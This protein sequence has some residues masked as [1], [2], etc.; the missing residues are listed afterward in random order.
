MKRILLL[1]VALLAGFFAAAENYLPETSVAGL[2]PL[3][4]SGRTVYNFNVGWRFHRGDTP[5]A[6]KADYNDSAWELVST[7][8][9]VML[10]P[11]EGSGS[12]NYQGIAWYRKH[13]TVP[14]D[15]A[16]KEIVLHFEA[17]MGKQVIY[18]NGNKVKEHFGG[19][20][21]ITVNLT[22]AGVAAG[23][24]CVVAL[25]A[26]NSDDGSYLPGKP[27]YVLD[28]AYHGGIYRDVWLIGKGKV[29]ITDPIE[30][31]KVAGGG[32][33]VHYDNIS[34]QSADIFVDT[35]LRN[36][37]TRKHTVTL[38]T[39]LIDKEGKVLLTN[40]SRLTLKAGESRTAQQQ[41]KLKT[42]NLWAPDTPYLYRMETRIA[43][44]GEP[45]DGGVLRIGIRKVE[46]KG[47]EGLW[48]NGKPYP[49]KLMGANRHQD[50]AYVGNAVPNSQQWNDAVRLRE[51]G[52]R[53]IRCAHYPQDPAFMDACDE[54][55][56]FVIVATPGWQFWNNDPS[57]A[58]RS[59]QNTRDMIRVERNHPCVIMWE[60]ILNETG[61]PLEFST[62]A[63]RVTQ[64]EFPYPGA[65]VAAADYNSKGVMENY[66]VIY[67]NSRVAQTTD[68]TVFT[69]EWGDMVDDWYAH[70]SVSRM[71]RSWGEIPML[72][73]VN[74]WEELYSSFYG[75]ASN[76]IGGALWH[77]FDHQ[78]GYH[79]DPFWG[80][81][82]DCFRQP[83]YS[84]WMYRSQLSPTLKVAHVKTG[85]MVYI[86]NEMTP[87]SN[88]EVV[89]FSNCDSVRLT[90]YGLRSITLPVEHKQGAM[91]SGIV[92]FPNVWDFRESIREA[93][94]NKT[95]TGAEDYYRIV[96]MVA[97]GIID[98]QVVCSD[99]KAPSR[100]SCKV[101][102]RLDDMEHPLV[103]DGS[104]FIVVIAEITDEDGNV[105][106]LAKE[107]VLFTVTGEGELIGDATNGANPRT[108][109]FGSAPALIRATTKAGK[110]K[111]HARVLYEGATAPR[112]TEIEFESVPSQ[113]AACYDELP[114]KG[115]HSPAYNTA[116][117]NILSA[118]ALREGL[119][120]VE[121]QQEE[122]SKGNNN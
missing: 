80:G 44:N 45:L 81:F 51:A 10:I 85:P 61:F 89:V 103:A 42:P 76:H 28:F 94:T 111:V 92:R 29:G 47:K 60:P 116:R 69:R 65:P 102:L 52:S 63:L 109:E 58:E 78:R 17:V 50:F 55:G 39:R 20:K 13:F 107:D 7:P 114:V 27:Q 30:A 34:E 119:R 93:N 57:F 82:M 91:P 38:Q 70:N 2:F 83:K 72:T 22:E 113:F 105:R 86:A 71:S 6:Y 19:Y 56:M 77:P 4:N 64:E 67:G 99:R 97:E 16:G 9:T 68:K 1:T 18:V 110:I 59:L 43:E 14:E 23:D 33:F 73:Q 40:N 98:G 106:R 66:P 79:P 15:L 90:I 32:I 11:A 25:M 48:L 53:I 121:S 37:D 108:V 115:S 101:T 122:Y 5:D 35:D 8:H 54:L 36:S 88:S 31:N 104:D 95:A 41:F 46:F 117:G 74:A 24:K 75:S 87:L 12:R 100:R 120:E 49:G 112:A 26:D 96:N 118:D 3:E 84:Y 62:D 21:P